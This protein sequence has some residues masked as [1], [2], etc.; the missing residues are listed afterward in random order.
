VTARTGREEREREKKKE[1]KKELKDSVSDLFY[2][3]SC[4]MFSNPD[5]ERRRFCAYFLFCIFFFVFI[6][7]ISR[8]ATAVISPSDKK[9]LTQG[10]ARRSSISLKKKP[11][12]SA[13]VLLLG[14]TKF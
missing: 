9:Q 3:Q 11:N 1:K 4:G 14:Q 8:T 7:S 6:L 12:N 13:N 10:L 2:K 5:S